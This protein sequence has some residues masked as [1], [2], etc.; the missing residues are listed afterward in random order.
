MFAFG[1]LSEIY[2]KMVEKIDAQF[3]FERR[4]SKVWRG[5]NALLLQGKEPNQYKFQVC[6][7]DGKGKREF[8]DEIVFACDAENALKS[9]QD[10][11]WMEKWTL[12]NVK[13]FDDVTL[14]HTDLEYIEKN[15]DI[16]LEREDQYFIKNYF[17]K[18]P[19]LLEMSFDLSNYQPQLKHSLPKDNKHKHKHIFQTIFLDK[20]KEEVWT[21][22]S[23]DKNKVLLKKWWRQFSHSYTHFLLVVPFVRFI[24]NQN[25]TNYCGSYCLV[26]THE[27]AT[28]SG[29]SSAF[30]ILNKYDTE[31][32]LKEKYPF[33][34]D[35][36]A[37][38]QFYNFLLFV[39]GINANPYPPSSSNS[40]RPLLFLLFLFIALIFLFFSLL[41]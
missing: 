3:H 38:K 6:V 11:S 12:G 9:L 2:E 18:H 37:S 25:N 19:H 5:K 34:T 17:P 15:Y 30:R 27:I 4:V 1:K 41:F 22:D 10:S 36:L 21:I 35:S 26:N 33:S 7:E 16:N 8:F 24:Q 20:T 28:I 39:H 23:I 32:L 13:Y 14:T 29:F 31:G 40:L